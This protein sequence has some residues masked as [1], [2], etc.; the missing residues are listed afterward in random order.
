[1]PNQIF[2]RHSYANHRRG[3][4]LNRTPRTDAA[5][6]IEPVAPIGDP[7]AHLAHLVPPSLVRIS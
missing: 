3:Q 7:F 6:F 2:K 4:A 1:M 5:A